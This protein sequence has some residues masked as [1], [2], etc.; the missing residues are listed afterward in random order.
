MR[1]LNLKYLLFDAKIF[2]YKENEHSTSV[3]VIRANLKYAMSLL[4]KSSVIS[5]SLSRSL[6]QLIFLK[7]YK[8]FV[9]LCFC[10]ELFC[11]FVLIAVPAEPVNWLNFAETSS[12]IS[13]A[14]DKGIPR[15]YRRVIAIGIYAKFKCLKTKLLFIWII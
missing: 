3:D 14:L 12:I 6:R 5:K 9:I 2:L 8:Q 1:F 11:N 7:N 10:W 4:I 15:F 13:I